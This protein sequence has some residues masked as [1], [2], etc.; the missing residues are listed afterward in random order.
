[1]ITVENLTKFVPS[2][3][4]AAPVLREVS[5]AVG[6]GSLFGLLGPSGAGKSALTKLLGLQDRPDAGLIRVDDVDTGRLD[7]RSLRELRSRFS[8]VDP[9]F[10]LRPERTVAGNIAT[11]LEQLGVDGPQRRDIVAELLDLVG[12]TRGAAQHPGELNEGQRRRVALARALAVSPSVLLVDDPTAGLDADEAGGVLAALDRANAELGVTVLLATSDADVVRKVCDGVAVL[13]DDG[14][15]VETGTVFELL[16][17]QDSHFAGT[18]LPPVDTNGTELSR[19]DSV[20]DVVLI[21]HAT[22]PTL[23]S[24]AGHQMGVEVQTLAGGVTR[25][26]ETPVAR[27]RVGLRGE[28]ADLAV[29]WLSEHSGIVR[30][31][32]RTARVAAVSELVA[33][34]TRELAGVAA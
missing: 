20:A 28:R 8:T 7:H 9:G 16:S 23:L 34:E 29:S 24:E 17:D 3:T 25:A 12:L 22:V 32:R 33:R 18:Q 31:V 2:A 4:S 10:V 21:G 5:F 26:G 1:M 13:S 15:L 19:Y 27:Y 6:S 14:A 11:P 30:P